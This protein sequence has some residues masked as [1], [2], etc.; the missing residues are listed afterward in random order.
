M[1]LLKS[2]AASW[3]YSQSKY[4]NE[5]KYL[6]SEDAKSITGQGINICAGLSVGT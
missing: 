3:L 1:L 6:I 4:S 5:V 2:S